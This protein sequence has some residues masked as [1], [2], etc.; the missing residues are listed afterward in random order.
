MTAP[1]T[2][3]TA[4]NR[5]SSGR[6]AAR[7]AIAAGRDERG[8]D[9]DGERD[10]LPA[11]DEALG[12]A[13]QRVEVERDDGDRHGAGQCIEGRGV[14]WPTPRLSRSGSPGRSAGGHHRR[15]SR[16]GTGALP[17]AGG[18]AERRVL[19]DPP[20]P[21]PAPGPRGDGPGVGA[22]EAGTH[23][24]RETR[25]RP[26]ARPSGSTCSAPSTCSTARRHRRPTRRP[27]RARRCSP[28]WS[29]PAG[30]GPARRSPPTS[31]RR[32]TPRRP[33][34]CGR[35]SGSSAT[36]S[37]APAST[38]TRS[39]TSARSRSA[40][41]PEARLEVDAVAFE[42]CLDDGECGA[43]RAIEL[44]RGDLVESLGHDCFAAERE[45]LADRYEDAL[46]TVAA[47]S[48][49]RRRPRRRPTGGRG[50][51]S[52]AIRSARRRTRSSSSVLGH[53]RFALAGRPAVPAPPGRPRPR[54]R[55]AAAPR[56]GRGLPAGDAPRRPAVDGAGRPRV[57]PERSPEPSSP[58]A[59][60][61]TDRADRAPTSARASA[62]I[63]DRLRCR[64]ASSL[65]V[66]R[67][68][69]RVP[70]RGS[71][72]SRCTSGGAGGTAPPSTSVRPGPSFSARPTV[73]PS[74][75]PVTGEVPAAVMDA[76][77]A[78][79]GAAHRDGPVRR[80]RRQGRGGRV[81]G[82]LAGLPGARGDVHRRWSRPGYQVVLALDGT[83]YDYRVAGEG[84]VIRLCEGLKPAGGG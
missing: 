54:A 80:D 16:W 23:T 53:D 69:R 3:P 60:D 6:S 45:R 10:R 56:D 36:G 83:S 18:G 32:P 21:I 8:G 84:D 76:V 7:R 81:A 57:E 17:P 42:R 48:A 19:G 68:R 15:R 49:R 58:S 20:F 29:W 11:H 5:R 44:Y 28:C 77:L 67:H 25:S 4:M 38:L 82:R 79:L 59:P 52:P 74:D 55:R 70:G 66:A 41:A 43:E 75:A 65:A 63:P 61:R 71:P 72:S 40:S 37:S 12:E 22:H 39:S 14:G 35:R 27:P 78:D 46:V 26:V 62:G 73:G 34:R 51:P 33:D 64:H 31:G 47:A 13:Q 30:R 50:G 24:C 1:G 9:D 2:I